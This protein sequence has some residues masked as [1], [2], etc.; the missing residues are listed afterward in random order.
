MIRGPRRLLVPG[1]VM[2]AA[3][4]VSGCE[5]VECGPGTYRDGAECRAAAPVAC[6]EGTVLRDGRCEADRSALPDGGLDCPPGTS[7]MGDACAPDP[8]FFLACEE[9]PAP[10]PGPGCDALEPGQYCVTGT[11]VDMVTGCAVPGDAGLV[12][13]LADPLAAI[14][15]PDAP[16]LGVAPVGPGGSFAIAAGG[17]PTL[18]VVTIDEADDANDDWTRSVTGVL[19]RPPVA[20]DT[21]RLVSMATRAETRAAW[22]AAL[23]REGDLTDGGFLVGRVLVDDGGDAAPGAGAEIGTGRPELPDCVDGDPCLRM[24][25]DDPALTGFVDPGTST[26]AGSGAFLLVHNGDG[27]LQLEFTATLDGVD[28]ANIIA[29]ANPGSGFHVVFT[30]TT[31]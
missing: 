16:P 11:V 18:L 22:A 1:I 31:D 9:G 29:G 13:A 28:F 12:V 25:D 30:P 17:E 24:F 8:V 4:A 10:S 14:L 6:G 2:S 23:G 20:G 21:Y 3:L 27:A 19:A 26:T 15:A 7:P 5:Q